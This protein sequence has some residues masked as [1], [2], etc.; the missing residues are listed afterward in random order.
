LPFGSA[1][2]PQ[3][4]ATDTVAF[5]HYD[6][7]GEQNRSLLFNGNG[8]CVTVYKLLGEDNPWSSGRSMAT[9]GGVEVLWQTRQYRISKDP[10]KGAAWVIKRELTLYNDE[11]KLQYLD[12][13]NYHSWTDYFYFATGYAAVDRGINQPITDSYSPDTGTFPNPLSGGPPS[14]GWANP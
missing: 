1:V 12:P 11:G 14:G 7:P 13:D 2:D 6:F 8:E 3:G 9:D 10:A 5:V 4:H